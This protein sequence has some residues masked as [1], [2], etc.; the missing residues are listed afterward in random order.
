MTQRQLLATVLTNSML[1]RLAQDYQAQIVDAT[2]G[3]IDLA[4]LVLLAPVFQQH[5]ELGPSLLL[6]VNV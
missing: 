3:P 1:S 2:R 5:L 4:Q 6:T